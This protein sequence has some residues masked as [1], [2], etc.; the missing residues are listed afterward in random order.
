MDFLIID[1]LKACE[2]THAITWKLSKIYF[3]TICQCSNVS[4]EY[5]ESDY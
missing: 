4:V 1:L 2:K 5:I 3:V